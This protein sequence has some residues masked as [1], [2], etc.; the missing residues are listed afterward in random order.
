[1]RNT[2]KR[3]CSQA[4]TVP[5]TARADLDQAGSCGWGEVDRFEDLGMGWLWDG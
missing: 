3:W 2:G 1:M 5:G 4:A